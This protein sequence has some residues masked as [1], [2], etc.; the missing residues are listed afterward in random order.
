M[1]DTAINVKSETI[2]P[3]GFGVWLSLL[4]IGLTLTVVR[5]FAGI[6]ML[7]SETSAGP[8]VEAVLQIVVGACCL[9][10]L[11]LLLKRKRAFVPVIATLMIVNILAALYALLLLFTAGDELRD[12]GAF[13]P[14]LFVQ[15]VV[16]TLW[17][18]YVLKSQRV[19][20][21]CVN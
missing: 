17:L 9:V 2:Q 12:Q 3:P 19:R 4:A 1:D 21:V 16:S 18:T 20:D 6:V 13:A 14:A 15:I 11:V 8:T 7:S 5:G 10:A